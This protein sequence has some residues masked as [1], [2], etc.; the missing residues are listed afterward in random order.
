[1]DIA[2]EK[3]EG[4]PYG[5]LVYYSDNGSTASGCIDIKKKAKRLHENKF[6]DIN[7][8]LH[9]FRKLSYEANTLREAVYHGKN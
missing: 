5:L 6:T 8:I 9:M 4:I 2:T 3:L 1:M 7:K